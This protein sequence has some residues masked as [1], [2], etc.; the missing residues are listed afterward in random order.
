MSIQIVLRE[1][2]SQLMVNVKNVQIILQSLIVEPNVI[3]L[4]VK[5]DKRS[6]MK[7]NVNFVKIT[8]HLLI[9]KK[10]AFRLIVKS[11]T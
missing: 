7:G 6:H 8:K 1:K 10:T 5:D 4:N 11:Y 3:D 2:S 9:A